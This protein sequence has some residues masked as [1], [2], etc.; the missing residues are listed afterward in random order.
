MG[1]NKEATGAGRVVRPRRNQGVDEGQSGVRAS[2][3]PCSPREER[4]GRREGL[5][6]SPSWVLLGSPPEMARG[7]WPRHKLRDGFQTAALAS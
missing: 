5:G 4:H 6:V 1:E 7:R 2:C 3:F